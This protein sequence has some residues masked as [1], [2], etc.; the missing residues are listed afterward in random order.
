MESM[1][2][3]PPGGFGQTRAAFENLVHPDDRAEVIKLLDEAL[4]TRQPTSGEWRVI[5]P[6]GSVRWIVGRWQLLMDDSGEPLRVVGV[7]L[8]ITERKRAEEELRE[9]E[10]KF[11]NVFRDGGVGMV[12]VSPEGRFLAANKAFCDCLGYTEEELLKKTVESVTFPEDRPAFSQKLGE[13]LKKGRG[14]QWFE[15]R[16][17]HKSGRIV[18][19]ES[20]ASVIRSRDGDPQYLVGQ[21]LD[22]TE[23]K[24]AQEA[25]SAMTRKLVEAQE[26]ERARIARELHDDIN[27]RL[28]MLALE[29]EQVRENH[30]DLPSEVRLRID[31]LRKETNTISADVQILSHDLHSSQLEYL[32]AVAGMKSWCKEFGERHGTQIDYRHNVRSILPPE[33]GLCLFRV[34]QE[35]MH[36]AV[37]HSGVKRIEVQL[38]EE[39]GEIHLSSV[40]QA[41]GSI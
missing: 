14:F 35:A 34:L 37:K 20:S 38:R 22:I 5:W 25:I 4:K 32:G 28:A 18:Y 33:I 6:D 21:V 23:R 30:A 36:N 7:N 1:Y 15:K 17:L 26:Q 29:L 27:Q 40:I 13:T 41:R 39:T 2:G 8:D 10:E 19:T 24:E 11:R 3:L 12:L 9:S 31:E 16:C